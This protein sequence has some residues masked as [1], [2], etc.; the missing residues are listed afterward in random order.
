[1]ISLVLV[2]D[3]VVK[4]EM[5]CDGVRGIELARTIHEGVDSIGEYLVLVMSVLVLY[6]SVIDLCS[7]LPTIYPVS[8]SHYVAYRYLVSLVQACAVGPDWTTG[9]RNVVSY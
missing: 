6:K 2:F 1:M 3:A 7:G 4:A 5:V 9:P 8:Y